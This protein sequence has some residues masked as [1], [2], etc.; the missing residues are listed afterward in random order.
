MM[1]RVD[2]AV[3]NTIKA[4]K[5]GHFVW[6]NKYFGLSDKGVDYALDKYNDS[7]IPPEMRAKVEKVR[8]DI[9]SGKIKVSD[10]YVTRTLCPSSPLKCDKSPRRTES[11]GRTTQSLSK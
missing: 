10:Y 11:S 1:K 8:D 3:Y 9:L 2:L 4:E 7:L 6:G 5:E